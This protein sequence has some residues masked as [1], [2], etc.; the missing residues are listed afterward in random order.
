MLK[1]G[2]NST[3]TTFNAVM[4]HC[5]SRP[6]LHWTVGKTVI[7]HCRWVQQQT[8]KRTAGR[9][10]LL[11]GKRKQDSANK[12]RN[13]LFQS[14]SLT[15]TLN[16]FPFVRMD[17]SSRRLDFCFFMI[18][19]QHLN[20]KISQVTPHAT[21]LRHI[22]AL[23]ATVFTHQ[24][25]NASHLY[26]LPCPI[27]VPG[28]FLPLTASSLHP[29]TSYRTTWHTN[30]NGSYRS[31]T[32][33]NKCIQYVYIVCAMYQQIGFTKKIALTSSK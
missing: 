26:T 28:L 5:K 9:W 19:H 27:C 13:S 12:V 14:L 20:L 18:F 16:L 25:L 11:L 6:A 17:L 8:P 4:Q 1:Q 15:S 32:Y 7:T 33:H 24:R 29:N 2:T 10:P 22:G 21:F 31:H 3:T 23:V 30:S